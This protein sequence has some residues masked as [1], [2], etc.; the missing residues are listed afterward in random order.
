[1]EEGDGGKYKR[2]GRKR[3]GKGKM[4]VNTVKL[5]QYGHA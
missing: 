3:K 4:E 2:K 1:M 5:N